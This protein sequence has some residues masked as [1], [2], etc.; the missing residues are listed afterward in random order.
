MA[1]KVPSI[2]YKKRRYSKRALKFWDTVTMFNSMQKSLNIKHAMDK[3]AEGLGVYPQDI[4]NIAISSEELY[5]LV[6]SYA[7][8]YNLLLKEDLI[9]SGNISKIQP[10]IH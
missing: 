10:T 9:K 1:E 7:Q 5:S 2:T 6:E 4:G 8:A 3:V